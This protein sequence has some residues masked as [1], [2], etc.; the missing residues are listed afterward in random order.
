VLEHEFKK[1]YN[2]HG[3]KLYNFIIWLTH[4]K[5]A[6]DDILQTVFIKVWQC[7][8]VPGDEIEAQRW[9]FTVARNASLDFF[10][11][12]TRFSRFRT[13]YTQEFYQPEEDP[14]A[15]FTWK[16]LD[17][18]PEVEKS[19]LFLHLKTGYTYKE[20]GETLELSENL[21]RVKAFRALKKL[22]EQLTK[23]EV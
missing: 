12:S 17:E 1:I 21:V 16:E 8:F 20:I 5:S 14:D 19:I 13:K 3:R 7:D 4:N 9:L 23:K 6:A 10:R 15:S 22:R 2:T 11:K 18:L